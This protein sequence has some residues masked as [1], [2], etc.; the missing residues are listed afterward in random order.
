M[1]L[2]T[3][4]PS[5][6]PPLHVRGC[7]ATLGATS[8]LAAPRGGGRGIGTGAPPL[9]DWKRRSG[10][11]IWVAADAGGMSWCQRPPHASLSRPFAAAVP[12]R[13]LVLRGWMWCAA[14][15]QARSRR[16]MFARS[17][18]VL[19][20][21]RA[22]YRRLRWGRV[23]AVCAASEAGSRAASRWGCRCR[24]VSSLV[25]SCS[26]RARGASASVE[27]GCSIYSC[28]RR[29]ILVQARRRTVSV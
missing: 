8:C 9:R 14:G 17:S 13:A 3:R 10:A 24:C 19:P 16:P 12:T 2:A 25:S 29:P 1:R 27:R 15:L 22:R 20:A 21:P 28:S 4:V 11:T 6:R 23:G 18:T 7:V 5:L 26:V